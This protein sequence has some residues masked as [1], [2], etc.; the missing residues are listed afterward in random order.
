MN[1]R[2]HPITKIKGVLKK[3]LIVLS[4]ILFIIFLSTTFLLLFLSVYHDYQVLHKGYPVLVKR[5]SRVYDETKGAILDKAI[6]VSLAYRS[7]Y[8]IMWE[9]HEN[10]TARPFSALFAIINTFQPENIDYYKYLAVE[11]YGCCGEFARSLCAILSDVAY[12]K[13]RIV[14]FQPP[15]ES[16]HAICEVY[17]NDTWWVFD[18]SWTT[19]NGTIPANGYYQYLIN[20]PKYN[21]SS[22]VRA[23][24]IQDVRTHQDLKKEHG[25][26]EPGS[27]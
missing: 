13:T 1:N 5:Y 8:T 14:V 18:T 6:N 10:C 17:L 20:S 11:S 25:F 15:N 16:N 23:T 3:S 7:K 19:P 22:I 27:E 21:N 2:I 26:P 12:V 9:K 4:R 24:T